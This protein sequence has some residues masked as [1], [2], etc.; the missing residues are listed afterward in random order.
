MCFQTILGASLRGR[1]K[2]ARSVAVKRYIERPHNSGLFF[3]NSSLDKV[4]GN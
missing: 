4:A 2:K 3:L 1:K